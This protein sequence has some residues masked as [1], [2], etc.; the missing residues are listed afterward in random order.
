MKPLHRPRADYVY[1]KCP[2]HRVTPVP[3]RRVDH[4]IESRLPDARRDLQYNS[5]RALPQLTGLHPGFARVKV[6]ERCWSGLS[7][8]PTSEQGSEVP[9]LQTAQGLPENA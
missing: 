3:W 9:A 2:V 6:P 5:T 1:G 7:R 4:L 8:V